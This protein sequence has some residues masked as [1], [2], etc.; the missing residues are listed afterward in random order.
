MSTKFSHTPKNIAWVDIW[1]RKRMNGKECL[2]RPWATVV[3]LFPCDSQ[4]LWFRSTFECRITGQY[5]FRNNSCSGI[6]HLFQSYRRNPE[7]LIY[8][9]KRC[10]SG[11]K[12]LFRNIPALPEKIMFQNVLNIGTLILTKVEYNILIGVPGHYHISAR[13]HQPMN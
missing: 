6:T 3:F 4:K 7:Q 11:T 8:S 1:G 9:E 5:L 13:P 10:Y 12:E 2:F